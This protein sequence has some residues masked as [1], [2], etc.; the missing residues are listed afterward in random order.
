MAASPEL[1]FFCFGMKPLLVLTT[2][3]ALPILGLVVLGQQP[4]IADAA[5]PVPQEQLLASLPTLQTKFWIQ[6]SSDT[7][8]KALAAELDLSVAAPS[9]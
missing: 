2:T 6:A 1:T 3:S 8:F 5:R 7:S 4:G 9:K